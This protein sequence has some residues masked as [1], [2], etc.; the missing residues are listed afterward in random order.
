[1]PIPLKNWTT[2]VDKDVC[3]TT[4]RYSPLVATAISLDAFRL[5]RQPVPQ[6]VNESIRSY[7]LSCYDSTVGTFKG[8]PG[9]CA[10]TLLDVYWGIKALSLMNE[11][12][13]VDAT[14]TAQYIAS[15][16]DTNGLFKGSAPVLLS[17]AP[18][19]ISSTIPL[20]RLAVEALSIIG[21]IGTINTTALGMAIIRFYNSSG[22]YFTHNGG[23]IA[24][25]TLATADALA[26]FSIIGNPPYFGVGEVPLIIERYSRLQ[27]GTGGWAVEDGDA[28]T[29]AGHYAQVISTL[30]RLVGR[31]HLGTININN[32]KALFQASALSSPGLMAYAPYPSYQPPL[33]ACRNAVDVA[34][35][36]HSLDPAAEAAATAMVNAT[37]T[38]SPYPLSRHNQH[39]MSYSDAGGFRTLTLSGVVFLEH[40]I[41]LKD[42]LAMPYTMVALNDILAQLRGIQLKDSISGIQGLCLATP[43]CKSWLS[44]TPGLFPRAASLES[45]LAM[46]KTIRT[47]STYGNGTMFTIETLLDLP[48]LYTQLAASYRESSELSWFEREDPA[49]FQSPAGFDN[50]KLRDTR[51]ALE[52]LNTTYGFTHTMISAIISI[53]KLSGLALT[54]S[55]HTV[56]DIDNALT[57]LSILNQTIPQATIISIIG[58]LARF[59]IAGSAWFSRLGLP[60]FD[61]TM[62]AFRILSRFKGL[63]VT[64]DHIL[65]SGTNIQVIS[66]TTITMRAELVNYFYDTE[67]SWSY[68]YI[69]LPAGTNCSASMTPVPITMP[70]AEDALGPAS[71]SV[72]MPAASLYPAMTIPITINGVLATRPSGNPIS[73]IT[74]RREPFAVIMQLVIVNPDN[75]TED[76]GVLAGSIIAQGLSI[77]HTGH[78]V[79]DNQS[80]SGRYITMLDVDPLAESTTYRVDA[81]RAYCEMFQATLVVHCIDTLSW[82]PVITAPVL[83]IVGVTTIGI[84]KTGNVKRRKV[85]SSQVAK[86]IR[87]CRR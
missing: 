54:E 25:T 72:S 71:I 16:L 47:L 63:R 58:E 74:T 79:L 45:T 2:L 21:K 64:L 78:F 46:V 42:A 17:P 28:V 30:V 80:S 40:C 62:K 51:L 34:R 27:V 39:T 85:S 73:I 50:A 56:T 3:L 26:I 8:V 55:R 77:N 65:K 44:T 48:L 68:T 1:M 32:L 38:G 5:L 37:D 57:I 76:T 31:D 14:K 7:I 19:Y 12:H 36:G 53:P 67:P 18:E 29:P 43:M 60:S 59:R 84:L 75:A 35:I 22:H 13:H 20:T 6:A 82:S 49:S 66:G 11:L 41:A 87:T 10:P 81:S 70:L 4:N 24:K 15:M 61:E 23:T 33:D 9:S 86:K 69:I 83:S 52:I